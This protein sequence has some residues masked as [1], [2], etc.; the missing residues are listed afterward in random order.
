MREQSTSYGVFVL[1]LQQ[2]QCLRRR[3]TVH[4]W[5]VLYFGNNPP[6]TV[7]LCY[8]YGNPNASEEVHAWYVLLR[9]GPISKDFDIV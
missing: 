3:M 9:G 6:L 7:F 1:C 8:I 4:V 2:Y 5:Y